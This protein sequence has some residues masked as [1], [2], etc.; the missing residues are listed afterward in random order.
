MIKMIKNQFNRIYKSDY[1]PFFI[2]LILVIIPHIL[3]KT[4]YG[5]DVDFR[6]RIANQGFLNLNK[7]FME[8]WSSKSI[9]I[10]F[11]LGFMRLPDIFWRI[12]DVFMIML[13]AFSIS[14][15]FSTPKTKKL[16]NW[17]IAAF[18][19]L[20]PFTHMKSAGWIS[21]T[22]SY[23]F[24]LAL[25]VFGL[26][27]IRKYLDKQK[28]RPIEYVLYFAAT[29]Y[30]ANTEQMTVILFLIYFVF[31]VYSFYKKRPSFFMIIQLLVCTANIIYVAIHPG[32]ILRNLEQTIVYFP[33]FGMMSLM[34]KIKL[35][36][37][38]TA[39][40]YISLPNLMFMALCSVICICVFVKYKNV[41]YRII[42]A[43]P[44]A[45]SVCSLF[46]P[47][48]YRIFP[49]LESIIIYDGAPLSIQT[50]DELRYYIPVIISICAFG[51]IAISLYLIF[52]NS[53]K[54]PV[55]ILIFFTGIVSRMLLSFASSL[56]ASGPRTF[57]FLY[58]AFIVCAACVC[59]EL[60]PTL[61]AKHKSILKYSLSTVAVLSYFCNICL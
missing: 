14:K 58:F 47:I 42:A 24:P 53:K 33:N 7:W 16:F 51:F 41:F 34:Q 19:L 61:N 15:I 50:M 18:F 3:L 35:G 45:I 11:M 17:F 36:A 27:Y 22:C 32:H 8:S 38:A 20:Y 39:A 9:I 30:A 52:E 57:I 44:F 56:Y 29:F 49:K 55:L 48:I 46:G 21:T 54:S 37:G 25:G 26:V 60:Y 2:L 59:L 6:A 43:I 5:D 23:I 13:L 40:H 10:F 12:F 1:F 4:N 28:V 31:M